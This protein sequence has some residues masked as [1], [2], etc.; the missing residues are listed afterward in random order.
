[1]SNA[2]SDPG[3]KGNALLS[4]EALKEISAGMNGPDAQF[5]AENLYK[6]LT[7]SNGPAELEKGYSEE[8]VITALKKAFS[9][10]K[11]KDMPS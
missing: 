8:E 2:G 6:Q 1:M 9:G 4:D 11:I 5:M 10:I 3:N 7:A